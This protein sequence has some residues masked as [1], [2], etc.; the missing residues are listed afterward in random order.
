MSPTR[1]RWWRPHP[2][3]AGL[4]ALASLF[5]AVSLTYPFGRDQALYGYVAREWVQRG[6]IP[7]RDVYDHKTPGIYLVHAITVL[8]FGSTFWGI[9]VAELLCVVTLGIVAARLAT[10]RTDPV[11]RGLAGLSALA[12]SVFYFGY[13]DYWN[14][15]QSEIWYATLGVGA[16]T[17]AA[18]VRRETLAQVWA[19]ALGAAAMV[20]KPPAIWMVILAAVV[21]AVRI[22]EERPRRVARTALGLLR[23]SGAFSAVV[24]VT[25][26]YFGVHH[27]LSAMADIVIGANSYY[28]VHERGV[29]SLPEVEQRIREVLG[30]HGMFT[31]PLFAAVLAALVVR[32]V[33]RHVSAA[34]RGVLACALLACGFAAVAMQ[35]KFYLLHWAV[36]VGP[37]T[38]AAAVVGHDALA[39]L[40]RR[41][42]VVARGA[43][44]VGAAVVFLL[45]AASF[46]G[47]GPTMWAHANVRA[48]QRWRGEIT[49][50]Q[51]V[52]EF[53][54][55]SLAYHYKDV[56][57]VGE[58]IG[59]N[60]TP[61][62][63]VAARGFNPEVYLLSGR[64]YAGRF[65]W[66]NFLTD[67]HRAYRREA[68]LAEDD[69]A[70]RA[71]NPRYVVALTFVHEGLD[72]A[73]Y[74]LPRGYHLVKTFDTLAILER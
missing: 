54:I 69:A 17:A 12:A 41:G 62:D 35:Q 29:Q 15:A 57:A 6:A 27:A 45:Y 30:I 55:D 2:I 19:G 53:A 22:F 43:P 16:V 73:E 42:G 63:T 23:F 33:R 14:T 3:D 46:P 36:L 11:P 37:V 34:E 10:P 58:W 65:F 59:E 51:Y 49:H 38:V 39:A 72:S 32:L 66:S 40:G 47:G 24:L 68:Y 61:E 7:Y 26:G 1:R 67:P 28:V 74:Y 52:G 50:E 25:L 70:F 13:F 44:V 48:Y 9:R 18:R 71:S 60:S 8:L 31:V 64:R 5:G 20:M 56:H 4:V 21:L